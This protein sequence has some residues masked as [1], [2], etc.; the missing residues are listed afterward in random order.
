M[1]VIGEIKWFGGYSN[2]EQRDLDY[3]FIRYEGESIYFHKD[4]VKCEV[5]HLQ[6]DT[7]VSFE[8]CMTEDKYQAIDVKLIQD[9]TDK[10]TIKDFILRTK[11]N[12][13]CN[14]KHLIAL[15]TKFLFSID[16]SK[17]E[18]IVRKKISLLST[19]DKINMLGILLKKGFTS[20]NVMKKFLTDESLIEQLLKNKDKLITK[21]RELFFSTLQTAISNT[22]NIVWS[23]I[24]EDIISEPSVWKLVPTYYRIDI[25][26]RRFKKSNSTDEVIE[27][28][29]NIILTNEN[30][31]AL[32][33]SLPDDIKKN[34]TILEILS[35]KEKLRIFCVIFKENG[36]IKIEQI[37][38]IFSELDEQSKINSLNLLP[39]QVK[40]DI[41]VFGYI[42]IYEQ[43][44]VL[45]NLDEVSI[46]NYWKEAKR[47]SK[48]MYLFKALRE[49]RDIEFL[50]QKTNDII[51]EMLINILLSSQEN[52][53][54]SFLK[55]N[56]FLQEDIIK[57]AWDTNK[58]LDYYPLLPLCKN[59]AT[60]YCEGKPWKS[61]NEAFCPRAN[62]GCLGARIKPDLN[63]EASDWS[64]LEF[65]SYEGI[66]PR[67][68]GLVNHS[69]YVNRFAGWTNRL[70]EIREI[71]KC[72]K[73]GKPLLSNKQYSKNLAVYNAT[74]FYC[75]E[76]SS[77]DSNVYISHCWACREIIDS[78]SCKVKDS[79]GYYLCKRCGSGAKNSNYRQGSICPNCGLNNM[80]CV[81]G[82]RKHV[83]DDCGHSIIIPPEFN[84]TGK[85]IHIHDSI[86]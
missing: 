33:L 37:V 63:L 80:H 26:V 48:I 25:L 19:S 47:G 59:F 4:S 70:L 9:E 78:R 10:N 58:E 82:N 85:I 45:W 55:F 13:F 69:E 21:D 67:V 11:W 51:V 14:N 53:E 30:K 27:G 34:E 15:L 76:G 68:P 56:Y 5:F 36:S 71:L 35:L 79:N 46:L 31:D 61:N 6:P 43:T 62:S 57:N 41:Y 75:N 40:N 54:N 52:K 29:K 65:I 16:F 23:E 2:K 83:C 64:L 17:A 38:S 72:S 84:W 77:H 24:S 28:L 66:T 39:Q 60:V 1:R 32:L 42:T 7:F 3:G 20:I 12:V 49:E 44:E 50:M 74:V 86:T 81:D 22:K 73:C 8:L 18:Y